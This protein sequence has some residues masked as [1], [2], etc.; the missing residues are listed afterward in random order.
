[1]RV[2]FGG[3]ANLRP[4][5]AYGWNYGAVWTPRFVPGLTLLLDFYHT[6]LRDR[7]NFVEPQVIIIQNFFSR[8]RQFPGQVVR[9][10][11][12]NII[13]V[14]DLTQNLSR[15]ITE[16]IDYG[17][18]YTFDTAVL[19]SGNFGTF[20]FTLNGNY[21]SR[22]IA[23]INPGDKE[24]DFS[25]QQTGFDFGYLPHHKL[26]A[27]AYYD[28]GGLDAGVTLHFI[29]QGSDL[30]FS[31]GAD[32]R[33]NIPPGAPDPFPRK[34]REW[35]SLDALVSY[36]FSFPEPSS[37]NDVAGSAKDGGK[38][39]S[40]TSKEAMSVSTAAYSQCGWRSWLNGTT[41]TV[42]MNNI[43]DRDPPFSSGAFE[44]GYEES[45]FDI[46]GR[47]WYV[48]VKKRF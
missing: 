43:F 24:L 18:I 1:V 16:G 42:G 23:A 28:L 36:T 26:Y 37:Q 6:D 20:T 11:A 17:A 7:T 30:P 31:T 44:N 33:A 27:S 47:F 14:R 5:V 41:L 39:A 9:D 40:L 25:G 3:Q 4:E 2:L 21:L 8:G 34:I 12:G 10:A 22:Y 13:L 15:T 32:Q 46:K 35:I 48:S 45:T 29:S 38:S 19:G